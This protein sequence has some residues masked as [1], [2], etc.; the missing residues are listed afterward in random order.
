MSQLIFNFNTAAVAFHVR[1]SA[2]HLVCS[3]LVS[4]AEQ[5]MDVVSK[6]KQCAA[7]KQIQHAGQGQSP[8]SFLSHSLPYVL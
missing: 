5:D 7:G 6:I 8:D 1:L 2:W 4:N 3:H